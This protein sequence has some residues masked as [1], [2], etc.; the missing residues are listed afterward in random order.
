MKNLEDMPQLVL[1]KITSF[2]NVKQ[3]LTL[4]QVSRKLK[5][6]VGEHFS[7][8]HTLIIGYLPKLEYGIDYDKATTKDQKC[9]D[10]FLKIIMRCGIRLRIIY[11]LCR[12]PTVTTSIENYRIYLQHIFASA[13]IS[14][15]CPNIENIIA[16]PKMDFI[17]TTDNDMFSQ[18]NILLDI[19]DTEI[20]A[21]RI[22]LKGETCKLRS[23]ISQEENGMQDFCKRTLS[24]F[25]NLEQMSV[26]YDF[27]A[28]F[29]K[30]LPQFIKNGL[31]DLWIHGDI[32]VRDLKTYCNIGK[33]L[34]LLRIAH[35]HFEN[36]DDI[37][38]LNKLKLPTNLEFVIWTINSNF[39]QLS[40]N[41]C[42][43]ICG[44]IINGET[45]YNSMSK[46]KNLREFCISNS[47]HFLIY[48]SFD[49]FNNFVFISGRI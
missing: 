1:D 17:T 3:L 49:Q 31:K 22:K 30:F 29:A 44:C 36:D 35:V 16:F 20:Y 23:M 42:N 47:V 38:A 19:A 28:E 25:L 4:E 48:C 39:T 5:R 10:G 41:V 33:D 15:N 24:L 45:D 7:I 18:Q 6:A 37:A 12:S 43:N 27:N 26:G 32:S 9:L 40:E 8:T 2:L 13:E 11:V 34:R 46:L 14:D 21:N